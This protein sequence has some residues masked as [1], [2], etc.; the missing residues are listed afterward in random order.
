MQRLMQYTAVGIEHD[1]KIWTPTA[2]QAHP[3]GREAEELMAR[4]QRQGAGESHVRVNQIMLTPQII[5]QLM[6]M[7]NLHR[8]R[9]AR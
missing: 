8:G 7:Q 2:E 3:P 4:N 9:V 1:V 5:A 6:R